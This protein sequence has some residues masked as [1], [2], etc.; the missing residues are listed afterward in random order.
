[1]KIFARPGPREPEKQVGSIPTL[2]G[3]LVRSFCFLTVA[4]CGART[5][6]HYAPRATAFVEHLR[7]TGERATTYVAI[8]SAMEYSSGRGRVKSAVH[9]V[10]ERG[11]RIRF[12]AEKSQANNATVNF[13][14]DGANF[15][16]ID[17]SR[18]CHLVGVCSRSAI[19]QL[20]GVGIAPDDFLTLAAGSAPIIPEPAGTARWDERNGNWIVDLVSPK[21]SWR[22]HLVLDGNDGDGAKWEVL[23]ST[24]WDSKGRIEWKLENKKFVTTKAKDGA[25]FGL[26]LHTRFAQPQRNT[27]LVI[28]WGPRQ[29]N[30]P[31]HERSRYTIMIRK[32]LRRCGS[33]AS[34]YL[35]EPPVLSPYSDL[36]GVNRRSRRPQPHTGIDFG[37]ALETDVIA[38]APGVVEM[39]LRQ[40]TAGGV[41]IL[42]HPSTSVYTAYVHLKSIYVRRGS[43]VGRGRV[44]GEVGLFLESGGIPHL[45]W[46][47][48]TDR[49]CGN[50]V[51][52]EVR[53]L[54]C[55]EDGQFVNR[56]ELTFPL[57]CRTE[58]N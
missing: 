12:Y 1:M 38:A 18:E 5:H 51:D 39:T 55:L 52:P 4:G 19:A 10:A 58:G 32:G 20:L 56:Y 48:C 37:A 34:T 49:L 27:D 47:V 8:N 44:L 29:L 41:V 26:P 2:I 43:R 50:R 28:A 42:F 33:R 3:R 7:A 23:S 40:P 53:S 25:V 6:P 35:R 16:L 22:Q 46:E 24:V 17:Y 31:P 30:G 13:A 21:G 57:S 45:H 15:T 36:L 11:G 14:C 9:V 54:S